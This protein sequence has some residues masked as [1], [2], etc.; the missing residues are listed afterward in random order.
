MHKATR[1]GLFSFSTP[2][3]RAFH[4]T[5]MA[6]FVCFFGWFACAPLIPVIKGVQLTKDQIANI[7]I[8]AVAVTI[9]V[10]LIIGRCVTV[11][12]PARHTGLLLLGAAGNRCRVLASMRHLFFRLAIQCD[13]RELRDHAV[14]RR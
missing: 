9:L 11:P 13:R 12:G 7:N 5:W 2:Q 10:R 6:F 1:I 8:A 14:P 3:M 4:L